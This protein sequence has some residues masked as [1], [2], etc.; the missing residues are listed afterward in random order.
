[1]EVM[2]LLPTF[3]LGLGSPRGLASQGRHQHAH[4]V[5]FTLPQHIVYDMKR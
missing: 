2:P 3:G 1:M 5:P 4:P